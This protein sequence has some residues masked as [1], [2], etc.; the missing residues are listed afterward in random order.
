MVGQ[1]AIASAK[2][3]GATRVLVVDGIRDRPDVAR[4]Q[5][6][7]TIDFNA[8]DP[9]E[10]V[11]D[12]TGEIG[13]DRVIDAVGVDAQPPKQGPAAENLPAD[14]DTFES[15]RRSAAPEGD[16][17]GDQW[18][19]GDAPSLAVRWAVQAVAKAGS[20]GVIG[21]YPPT[22]E[23]FPFGEAMNR[24]LTIQAGNCN[25][26]GDTCRGCSMVLAYPDFDQRHVGWLKTVV[27]M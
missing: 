1:C 27:P 25:P 18:I 6:A 3:Q 15:E 7:E 14:T 26:T 17:S 9:V 23:A 4:S 2:R 10:V 19:P 5:N 11:R 13:V 21:L 12:L 20:V 8:E 24:N 22:L 16:T